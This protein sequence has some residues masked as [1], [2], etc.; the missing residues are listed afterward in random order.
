MS[1][2]D[3]SIACTPLPPALAT[4]ITKQPPL[5]PCALCAQGEHGSEHLLTWCPAVALAWRLLSHDADTPILHAIHS[6]PTRRLVATFLHQV[7]FF[8]SSLSW[9]SDSGWQR[10]AQHLRRSTLAN[11]RNVEYVFEETVGLSPHP[12]TAVMNCNVGPSTLGHAR[13]V[14]PTLTRNSSL[15][16]RSSAPLKTRPNLLDWNQRPLSLMRSTPISPASGTLGQLGHGLGT[17]VIGGHNPH[18]HTP[19]MSLG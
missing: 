9:Y 13:I 10:T 6:L 7:S 11:L 16:V 18:V 8:A 4:L 14:F 5:D 12:S 1:S 19:L 15:S 3:F 2:Q 17:D